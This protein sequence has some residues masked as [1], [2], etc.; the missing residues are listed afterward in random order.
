M[1]NGNYSQAAH[2]ALLRGR[3]NIPMEHVFGQ[4]QCHPLMNPKGVKLRESRDSADHPQS[5]GIVFALDVSGSMGEI[6]RIM[7]SQQLPNFMKVLMD[8]QIRDPQLLFMAIGNAMS[9]AAPLQVG[10]FESTAQ[11]MDQWLTWTY[12]EGG[13]GGEGESYELGLYFLAAHTEMDC[14]VKRNKRGYLFMTGDETPFPTLSKHI[15]E[16]IIGDKLDE[17]LTCEEIVAELQKTYVPFFIIPDRARARRC[18]RRWRD[19]FGDHVLCLESPID[20][21]FVT[22]GAILLSEGRVSDIKELMEFLIGAGMPSGR[23]SQVIRSLT[24]FAEVILNIKHNPS[25]LS[26]FFNPG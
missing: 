15:V 9:D 18:E 8:C 3:A 26:R 17:D 10:Q 1:G 21:C 19:L 22:A 7:A 14:M 16:G 5:Q 13:G 23:R 25:W 4:T 12:L 20:I 2:E 24:P 11:L 6:P